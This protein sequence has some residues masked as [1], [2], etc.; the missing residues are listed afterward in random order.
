MSAETRT[1]PAG[2]GVD[3]RVPDFFIVGHAKCGTTA[4]YECCVRTLRSSCR[5]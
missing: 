5:S 2:E 4:L 3:T 1:P